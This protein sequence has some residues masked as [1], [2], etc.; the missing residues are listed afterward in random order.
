[1]GFKKEQ[2]FATNKIFIE[3]PSMVKEMLLKGYEWTMFEYDTIRARIH[4]G[5]NT[6][7]KESYYKGSMYANWREILEEPLK[8]YQGYI[9]IKNRAP[10]KLWEEIC[11]SLK[12][13]KQALMN[14]IFWFYAVVA[15][16]IPGWILRPL[17]LFYRNRIT[18]NFVKII[19]R[20]SK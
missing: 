11:E 16:V 13:N 1:M 6:G 7:T 19:E 8:F 4:P 5:G 10:K 2:I 17:S 3:C 12:G 20:K 14:P 15:V 9:Q 18:R